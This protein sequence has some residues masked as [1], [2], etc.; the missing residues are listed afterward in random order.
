[1]SAFEIIPSWDRA[2]TIVRVVDG[3]TV[4]VDI[5]LGFEIR[6]QM[7][8]RV[9]GINCPESRSS[10]ERERELGKQAKAFAEQLLPAGKMVALRSHKEAGSDRY[11]RYLAEILVPVDRV[12]F[13][14]AMVAAGHAKIWFG[15][16]PKP[17]WD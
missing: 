14:A 11:G 15:H 9:Y 8:V 12:D 7:R 6:I 2:A 10:D 5:D 3:D 1:M 17:T 4:D 13:A 16:G